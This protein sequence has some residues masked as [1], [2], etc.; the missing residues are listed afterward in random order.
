MLIV[1]ALIDIAVLITG[2][3][4][5]KNNTYSKLEMLI[6][7]KVKCLSGPINDN[8]MYL[9]KTTNVFH[10][11]LSTHSEQDVITMNQYS[12]GDGYFEHYLSLTLSLMDDDM[13]LYNSGI[14][15]NLKGEYVITAWRFYEGYIIVADTSV[16]SIYTSFAY[17]YGL[18][19]LSLVLTPFMFVL[20]VKIIALIET[21]ED[22]NN[23]YKAIVFRDSN[24]LIVNWFYTNDNAVFVFDKTNLTYELNYKAK[25][26]VKKSGIHV[27]ELI[28]LFSVP[29]ISKSIILPKHNKKY[30]VITNENTHNRSVVLLDVD[31]KQIKTDI[32]KQSSKK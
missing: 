19:I 26:V 9:D 18:L 20:L 6:D 29:E 1:F 21:R 10:S 13:V 15:K 14:F 31:N 28:K 4:D 16:R 22:S 12:K 25:A 32:T 17:N 11:L 23:L 3:N 24:K 2:Y 8:Y 5:E 7:S 27:N 30:I